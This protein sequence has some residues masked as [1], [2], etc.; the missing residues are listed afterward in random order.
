MSGSDCGHIFFWNKK[1]G[2]IENLLEAD[3]HVVNCVQENPSFPVLASSGIDYNVKLWE[4][5]LTES[6]LNHQKIETVSLV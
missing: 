4:P 2:R 6:M 1:T 3:K 5:T